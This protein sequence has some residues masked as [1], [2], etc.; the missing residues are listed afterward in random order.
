MLTSEHIYQRQKK[1]EKKDLQKQLQHNVMR[2]PYGKRNNDEYLC[3][4]YKNRH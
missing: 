2:Q 3:V 1:K 4:A